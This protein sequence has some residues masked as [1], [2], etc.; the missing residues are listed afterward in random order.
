[1]SERQPRL[2]AKEVERVLSRSGFLMIAQSG[3][4]RKWLNSDLRAMVIVPLHAGKVL[5]IG[6]MRQI[7]KASGIPDQDW[8]V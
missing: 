8:R 4:H 3:S 5:P 7:M 2:T 6:T 1:M